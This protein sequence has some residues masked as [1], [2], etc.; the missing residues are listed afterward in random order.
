MWIKNKK[1]GLVWEI[2]NESQKNTLLR[3]P[4]YVESRKVTAEKKSKKE[5]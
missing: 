5:D 2:T 3:D 1:T 4:D